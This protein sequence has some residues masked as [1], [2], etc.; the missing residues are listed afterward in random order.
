MTSKDDNSRITSSS[1]DNFVY[2]RWLIT[3]NPSFSLVTNS[4]TPANRTIVI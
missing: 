3:N 4:S 1:S 2:E